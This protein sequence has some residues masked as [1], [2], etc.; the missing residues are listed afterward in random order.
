MD[1]FG[2][3]LL[4]ETLHEVVL[5][6]FCGAEG[7]EVR[8][9]LAVEEAGCCEEEGLAGGEIE[10]V[11]VEKLGKSPLGDAVETD[12]DELRWLEVSEVQ[13]EYKGR[14]IP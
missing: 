13:V 14:D 10:G 3:E 5:G 4:P 11:E 1:A 9:G 8:E 2:P 12:Y 7:E 6:G